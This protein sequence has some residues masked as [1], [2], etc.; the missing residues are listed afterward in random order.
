[1]SQICI[2]CVDILSNFG[3]W[4]S[5]IDIKRMNS[6]G[7][8]QSCQTSTSTAT[9]YNVYVCKHFA[10][11]ITYDDTVIARQ[12]LG[13]VSRSC[14]AWQQR[15]L[16]AGPPF[17]TTVH[18]QLNVRT[19]DHLSCVNGE[20]IWYI[21]VAQIGNTFGIPVMNVLR[22]AKETASGSFSL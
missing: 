22:M 9:D 1:M 3:S 17:V 11:K 21:W 16:K 15:Q 7:T 4:L 14:M 8:D 20:N 5:I 19:S 10:I 2:K 12:A 18:V 6:I 13:T